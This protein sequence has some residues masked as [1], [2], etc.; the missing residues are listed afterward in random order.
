LANFEK[1]L[2]YIFC[3]EMVALHIKTVTE[4]TRKCKNVLFIF[5][6][7][8][9]R[10]RHLL[11]QLPNHECLVHFS[12]FGMLYITIWQPCYAPFKSSAACCT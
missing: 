9:L 12:Y 2:W 7:N 3:Y 10:T 8:S 6:K 11:L 1:P 4:F 5:T